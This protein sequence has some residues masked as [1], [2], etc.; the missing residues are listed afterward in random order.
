MPS[1][2][3]FHLAKADREVYFMVEFRSVVVDTGTALGGGNVGISRL[4]E[5]QGKYVVYHYGN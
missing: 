1:M 3:S 4:C 5:P 2:T